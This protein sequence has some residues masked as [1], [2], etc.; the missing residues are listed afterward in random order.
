MKTIGGMQPY[1]FPYLGYFQ[2]I[3]AVDV[4]VISDDVQYIK[5]GWINRNRIQSNRKPLLFTFGIKKDKMTKNINQR[6]YSEDTYNSTRDKFLRTLFH[7]YH[8]APYFKEVNELIAEILSYEDHN[9]S[10]FNTN[11]LRILCNY[12]NINT[13]FKLSSSLKKDEGLTGQD[14][15][16][17]IN[18]I[19][20]SHCCINAIGGLELYSSKR[21]E[22][23][24]IQLKFIKM[25]EIEYRQFNEHFIPNL[26]IIDVL[27]FNSEEEVEELLKS[28]ELR[29]EL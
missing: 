4:F 24:G 8:K 11:S 12:M 25:N 13:R 10:G 29:S 3:N 9:V 22:E 28:Y 26:S 18:K 19:L 1:L 7:S 15:V 23:N 2:L 17:A 27:M 6:S 21:F 16:I 14:A 20:D 5:G